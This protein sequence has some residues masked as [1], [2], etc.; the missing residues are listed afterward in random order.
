MSTHFRRSGPTQS[1]T[2]QS[3]SIQQII[4]DPETQQYLHDYNINVLY[5]IK[6]VLGT[7]RSNSILYS[8]D[9]I[10]REIHAIFYPQMDI[11]KLRFECQKLDDPFSIPIMTINV[12]IHNMKQILLGRINGFLELGRLIFKVN[13]KDDIKDRALFYYQHEFEGVILISLILYNIYILKKLFDKSSFPSDMESQ[14]QQMQE[15][16]FKYLN[17]MF[18][19]IIILSILINKLL[20][21]KLRYYQNGKLYGLNESV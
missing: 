19:T 20:T 11:A 6:H 21:T 1:R 10:K 8:V 2:R 15:E 3:Q 13:K 7:H 12:I 4:Y 14:S 9:S 17:T 16:H 5:E 18:N